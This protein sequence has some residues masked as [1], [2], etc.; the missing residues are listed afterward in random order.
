MTVFTN[1]SR[2]QKP[3]LASWLTKLISGN[4]PLTIQC[5]FNVCRHMWMIQLSM[6]AVSVSV[7]CTCEFLQSQ[8]WLEEYV[9]EVHAFSMPMSNVI[10]MDL[11]VRVFV[12]EMFFTVRNSQVANNPL[13]YCN[14]SLCVCLVAVSLSQQS[15][16]QHSSSSRKWGQIHQWMVW[17]RLGQFGHACTFS[18]N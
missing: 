9:Y 10:L 17:E 13:S 16:H 11:F 7:F 8:T 18:F 12:C 3:D 15:Y 5:V 1:S 4:R 14:R 2:F 6:S